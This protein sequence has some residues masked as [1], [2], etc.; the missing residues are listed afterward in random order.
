MTIPDKPKNR[1][2]KYRLTPAGKTLAV[3]I[4]QRN[5]F[6]IHDF[7]ST[8]SPRSRAARRRIATPCLPF[9]HQCSAISPSHLPLSTFH[10]SLFTFYFLLFTFPTFPLAI[11]ILSCNHARPFSQGITGADSKDFFDLT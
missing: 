5:D 4:N 9:Q 1:L 6:A 3:A 7:V 2:Q 11:P 8:S 10:L